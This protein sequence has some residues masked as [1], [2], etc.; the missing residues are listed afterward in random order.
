MGSGSRGKFPR[1]GYRGAVDE[2][3][4]ELIDPVPD[5]PLTPLLVVLK[6]G[7][8]CFGFVSWFIRRC[9]RHEQTA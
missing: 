2:R 4:L 7:T 5:S 8:S 9:Q 1:E 6:G 3:I